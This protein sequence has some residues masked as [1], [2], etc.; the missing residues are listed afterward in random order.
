MKIIVN[1]VRISIVYIFVLILNIQITS[2]ESFNS[3]IN[4]FPARINKENLINHKIQNG[5]KNKFVDNRNT[6]NIAMSLDSST[7]AVIASQ[8]LQEQKKQTKLTDIAS[9]AMGY[10]IGIGAMTVYAPILIKIISQGN[11]DGFSVA[12]WAYNLIGMSAAASYPMKKGFPVSSYI[13][14]ISLSFQSILL[15]GVICYYKGLLL[16]YMGF[17]TLYAALCGWFYKSKQIPQNVLNIIQSFA[18]FA[19]N[20]ANIP[21]IML[22]YR[23][24]TASWSLITALMSVGGNFIRILTTLH[25]TKDKLV[26]F[27]YCL[28][29]FTNS[30]LLAQ[31]FIYK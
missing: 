5:L 12:T 2:C 7:D 6:N 24:K 25:V 29:F 9:K 19:C 4:I 16:Q 10:I 8:M 13:E 22:N 18:I 30:I 17:M 23:F 20:Y 31:I 26:L 27:G 15:L 11:A 1:I 14:L 21:Q 28:G 3:F